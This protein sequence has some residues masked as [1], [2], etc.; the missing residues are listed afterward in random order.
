MDLSIVIPLYNAEAYIKDCLSSL[1][2]Q[3]IDPGRYEIMVVDDGSTDNSLKVAKDFAANYPN[4]RVIEQE[5]QGVSAA[6]NAGIDQA[7]GT[8]LYFIDA[9]DYLAQN[10]LDKVLNDALKRNLDVLCFKSLSTKER[11]L[12]SYSNLDT[13]QIDSQILT[14]IEFIANYPIINS[15]WWFIVKKDFLLRNKLQFIKGIWWEDVIF[16]MEILVA[17]ER[18]SSTNLDV[19]RYYNNPKSTI[20]KK[21]AVHYNKIIKDLKYV[22]IKMNEVINKV[23]SKNGDMDKCIEKIKEKQ[24]YFIFILLARLI[25]SSMKVKAVGV[26]VRE[27]KSYGLYPITCFPGKMEVSLLN[28]M[29]VYIFNRFYLLFP[30]AYTIKMLNIGKYLRRSKLS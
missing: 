5:N 4:V 25:K 16:S 10:T 23:I 22:V 28:K 11:S 3:S 1:V 29:A 2:K 13:Y 14:G 24:H 8:Y 18:V 9:D 15:V 7:R 30:F 19:H 17:A 27:L 6:R 26:Y 20:N 21:E 12:P